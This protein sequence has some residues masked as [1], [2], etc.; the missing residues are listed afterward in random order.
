[1]G[2]GRLFFLKINRPAK[3]MMARPVRAYPILNGQVTHVGFGSNV[4][5]N[6]KMQNPRRGKAAAPTRIFK[7]V[8]SGCLELGAF[9]AGFITQL[10]LKVLIDKTVAAIT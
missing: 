2:A 6:P 7:V 8:G 10:A 9:I 3:N 4:A 5:R 1:L